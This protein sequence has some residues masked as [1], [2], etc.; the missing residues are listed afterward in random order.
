M[1]M[2]SERVLVSL[3]K[4]MVKFHKLNITMDKEMELQKLLGNQEKS[5]GGKL[6]MTK[7]MAMHKKYNMMD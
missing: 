3:L 7:E 2:V 1:L 4:K 6:K 5:T